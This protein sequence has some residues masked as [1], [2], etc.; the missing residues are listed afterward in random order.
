MLDVV[1]FNSGTPE[2]ENGSV[3]YV[4]AAAQGFKKE[5]QS[6]ALNIAWIYHPLAR[7]TLGASG[8]FC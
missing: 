2:I 3:G 4:T 5:K 6:L 1:G 7:S 8:I